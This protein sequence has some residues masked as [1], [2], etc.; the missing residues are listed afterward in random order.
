MIPWSLAGVHPIDCLPGVIYFTT[1]PYFDFVSAGVRRSARRCC[2]TACGA[3]RQGWRRVPRS[4][5]RLT[6]RRLVYNHVAGLGE[7]GNKCSISRLL[8][9][10]QN[11]VKRYGVMHTSPYTTKS[12]RHLIDRLS[13][14][15]AAVD[16]GGNV[17]VK[18]K[19]VER[20][21]CTR[22]RLSLG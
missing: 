11:T 10:A 20:R 22:A 13:N 19:A 17:A 9:N 7:Y 3:K 1:V 8:V 5:G 18:R 6:H 12:I 4:G 14:T 2:T 16:C 21:A 15:G